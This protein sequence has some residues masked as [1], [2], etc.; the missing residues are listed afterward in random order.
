MSNASHVD[1]PQIKKRKKLATKTPPSESLRD[2][3]QRVHKVFLGSDSWASYST[4]VSMT[5]KE[6]FLRES[7]V[8]SCLCGYSLFFVFGNLQ[9]SHLFPED[10]NSPAS[11]SFGTSSRERTSLRSSTR[12]SASQQSSFRSGSLFGRLNNSPARNAITCTNPIA[13]PLFSDQMDLLSIHNPA[14]RIPDNLHC[15]LELGR[16][17]NCKRVFS[18]TWRDA[19]PNIESDLSRRFRHDPYA[20]A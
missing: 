1:I 15:F 11:G 19:V 16:I 5:F 12:M 8:T 6:H 17:L 9:H 10:K 13:Q 3:A 20:V 4:I 18:N 2:K 7:L 14:E